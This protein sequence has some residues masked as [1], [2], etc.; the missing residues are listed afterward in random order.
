MVSKEQRFAERGWATIDV[1]V[2]LL[3]IAIALAATANFIHPISAGTGNSN[4]QIALGEIQR[5]HTRALAQNQVQSVIFTPDSS[6][7]NTTITTISGH[8]PTST[9]VDTRSTPGSIT[10]SIQSGST[11]TAFMLT[12]LADGSLTIATTAVMASASS[13]P[14][15]PSNATITFISVSYSVDCAS[16]RLTPI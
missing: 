1:L 2:G 8:D 10:S 7:T 16:G 13:A 12:A 15:C 5:I 6:G 9:P 4:A 14:A 3:I 11:T